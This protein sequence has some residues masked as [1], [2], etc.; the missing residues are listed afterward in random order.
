MKDLN[1]EKHLETFLLSHVPENKPFMIAVSGGIDSMALVSGIAALSAK[2]QPHVVHIDHGWR[3]NSGKEAQELGE[4]IAHLRI[5]FHSFRLDKAPSG[6]N[7]EDWSRRARMKCFMDLGKTLGTNILLLAHHADDQIEVV[8]KRMLEGSSIKNFRGMR[9]LE[10]RDG[11]LLMRPLLSFRKKELQE[12]LKER[13]ISHFDDPTN[14]DPKFLRARFRSLLLP[15]LRDSFGKEFEESILR[16]SEEALLLDEWIEQSLFENFSIGEGEG[17]V[18]AT[19]KKDTISSF[20]A[21]HLI[22]ELRRKQDLPAPSRAQ[23]SEATAH[24]LETK[25]GSRSFPLGEGVILVEHHFIAVLRRKL[26]SLETVMCDQEEGVKNISCWEISWKKGRVGEALPFCWTELL[27]GKRALHYI[28]QKPFAISRSS[29]RLLKQVKGISSPSSF[30]PFVPAIIQQDRLVA[31]YLTGY[32][33][34]LCPW[35]PCYEIT[36]QLNRSS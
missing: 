4:K 33:L 22:D 19:V 28:P 27:Q 25:K 32:S 24:F 3:S 36:V 6:E 8:L 35:D 11:L 18:F 2:T 26:A 7:L 10:K 34:S 30:R 1:L 23:I 21:R 15:S 9:A 5:P 17:I 29:D 14:R 16:V 20:L 31:D 12:Y 13:K